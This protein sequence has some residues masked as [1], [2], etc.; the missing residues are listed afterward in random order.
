ME[1]LDVIALPSARFVPAAVAG[2]ARA[3]RNE[4][5]TA[6]TANKVS[7]TVRLPLMDILSDRVDGSRGRPRRPERRAARVRE[8]A[9]SSGQPCIV[10]RHDRSRRPSPGRRTA[11]RSM[12]QTTGSSVRGRRRP[13]GRHRHRRHDPGHGWWS[14]RGHRTE[15]P[16]E[17]CEGLRE[18]TT[19]AKKLDDLMLLSCI[20]LSERYI[21]ATAP[22]TVGANDDG[23]RTHCDGTALA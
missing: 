14:M 23:S 9:S 8:C 10:A 15:G 7:L 18:L 12:S 22:S 20:D 17:G 21:R 19:A 6:A 1:P 16:R 2:D 11:V 4:T 3:G 13:P 5:M